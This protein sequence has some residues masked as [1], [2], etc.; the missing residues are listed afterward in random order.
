MGLMEQ[1]AE[2]ARV[3]GGS[4]LDWLSAPGVRWAEAI[5]AVERGR[6]RGAGRRA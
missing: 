2:L 4:A 5:A 1:A 6:R 3:L